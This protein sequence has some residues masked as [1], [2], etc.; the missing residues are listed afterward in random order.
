VL[1]TERA[2]VP[3][4]CLLTVLPLD[5]MLVIVVGAVRPDVIAWTGGCRQGCPT[6]IGGAA[7]GVP[8]PLPYPRRP[9]LG[10]PAA[11]GIRKICVVVQWCRGGSA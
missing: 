3:V 2:P 7:Q 1:D 4:G 9:C 6:S 11:C 5:N 8:D 10:W